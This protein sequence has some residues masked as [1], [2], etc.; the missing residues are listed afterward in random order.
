L[1]IFRVRKPFNSHDGYSL[2]SFKFTSEDYGFLLFFLVDN[3]RSP[4]SSMSVS[5]VESFAR[6]TCEIS[7]L[8]DINMGPSKSRSGPVIKNAPLFE[9]PEFI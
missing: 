6:V 9:S 4:P 5:V 2:D 1:P 8:I 3:I 7:G